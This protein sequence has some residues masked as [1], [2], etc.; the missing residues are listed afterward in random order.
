M[1]T[2]RA[3]SD[4]LLLSCRC[5]GKY[6]YVYHWQCWC[7]MRQAIN[8]IKKNWES[9]NWL[10]QQL[11]F[12]S[13]F[14]FSFLLFTVVAYSFLCSGIW[15]HK[16]NLQYLTQIVEYCTKNEQWARAHIQQARPIHS[17]RVVAVHLWKRCEDVWS[18][19]AFERHTLLST[20]RHSLVFFFHG[21]QLQRKR[22]V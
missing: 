15:G 9:Q 16:E 14:S 11:F 10:P 13:V 4:W 8:G 2:S 17:L 20:E 19:G 22:Q 3:R 5:S 1:C 12:Y 6:N 18:G 7:S 21:T